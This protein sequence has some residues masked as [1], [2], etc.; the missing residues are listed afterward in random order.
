MKAKLSAMVLALA[1]SLSAVADTGVFGSYVAIDADGAGSAS[2]TWYGAQQPGPNTLVGFDGLDLGSFAQG[3]SATIAG[4]E[5]LTWKNGGSNVTGGLLHWRID[6]GAWQNVSIGFT[7]NAAFNDA[8]GNTF[9]GAGDQKW[10]QLASSNIDFLTGLAAGTHT[11]NVYF[12]SLTNAG[13]R[14]SGSAADPFSAN[15]AVTAVPEP[16]SL[17]MMLGGLALVGAAV[18]R[19]AA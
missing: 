2:Y 3:A 12:S 9:S 14:L 5:L 8:A 15:F 19:R 6:G 17:A 13:D 7:S 18:R 16:A 10:A 11:L 4:A 1:T